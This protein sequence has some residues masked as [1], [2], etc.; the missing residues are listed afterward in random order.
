MRGDG[1]G[2]E[3]VQPFL[4]A[5]R[6]VYVWIFYFPAAAK[7]ISVHLRRCSQKSGVALAQLLPSRVSPPGSGGGQRG[8]PGAFAAEALSRLV[9]FLRE[10][11]PGPGRTLSVL[12]ASS[13]AA[14]EVQSTPQ[15]RISGAPASFLPP[16]ISGAHS[17]SADSP[18]LVLSFYSQYL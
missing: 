1:S 8:V 13:G 16:E 5:G 7:G 3:I 4:L 11:C 18:A 15:G 12:P 6:G 14:P 9:P 17:A 2:D 10:S